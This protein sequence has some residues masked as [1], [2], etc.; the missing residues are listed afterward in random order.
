MNKSLI[1]S[2][3]LIVSGGFV[4]AAET[5][6]PAIASTTTTKAAT[7][8]TMPTAPAIIDCKYKISSTTK[9]I[10]NAIV[11][12]WAEKAAQQTFDFDAATL[13]KQMAELKACYTVEG[14]ESF[15]NAMQQSG[16][17]KVIQTQ[18][19]Q[20]SSMVNGTIIVNEEKDNQWKVTIP[21]QVVYQNENE[22]LT[23]GLVIDLLVGR[24]ISGDLGIMQIIASPR[25]P[26]SSKTDTAKPATT[27]PAD[28]K[29][30]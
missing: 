26:E 14:W 1:C 20:V 28:A 8:T 12:Q 4:H 19:L 27:A 23:Q 3:L 10:D 6:K 16:N 13:D 25:Q 2:G 9:K 24:K 11:K 29:K 15:N 30:P 21:M 5:S 18:K 17:L 7:P 22:K